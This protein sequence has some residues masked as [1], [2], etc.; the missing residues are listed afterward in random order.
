MAKVL[1]VYIQLDLDGTRHL[2]DALS[3][4]AGL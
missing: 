4:H 3:F 1:L 2:V